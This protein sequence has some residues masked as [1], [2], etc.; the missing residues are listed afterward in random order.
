MRRI[1]DG[2]WPLHYFAITLHSYQTTARR[3]CAMLWRFGV[4]VGVSVSAERLDEHL[5]VLLLATLTRLHSTCLNGLDNARR[6]VDDHGVS[7]KREDGS[8]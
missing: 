8:P 7:A 4:R 5:F 3:E 2:P 1:P 6:S